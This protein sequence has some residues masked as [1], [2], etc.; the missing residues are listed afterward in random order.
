M[1]VNLKNRIGKYIGL[2]YSWVYKP[3][4]SKISVKLFH[5]F[6]EIQFHFYNI[7]I[8]KD[9]FMLKFNALKVS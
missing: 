9:D 4:L 3:A 2:Y 8:T 7:E 5:E 6:G 1:N